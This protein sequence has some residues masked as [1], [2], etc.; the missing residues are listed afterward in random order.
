VLEK[1]GSMKKSP[2]DTFQSLVKKGLR[3]RLQTG[4]L[5]TGQLYVD[6]DMQPKTPIRLAKAGGPDPELPTVPANLEQMTVTL[7]GILD[8]LDQ[9]DFA[10]IGGDLQGT[11]KGTNRIANNPQLER[12][13]A[14]LSASLA[15]AKGLLAKVDARAEP[16]TANLEQ[17]LAAARDALEKANGTM[18]LVDSTLSA[19]PPAH[20]L[21][22]ELNETARALRGLVDMLERNPQ[23]LVFGR[24]GSEK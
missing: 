10:A 4:N 2:H 24:K 20:S 12:S 15:S 5:L 21:G 16:L 19:D 18:R 1:S 17:A 13:L 3:A 22:H 23:A 7:K 9:V 8:K 14:D 6:L 11:L